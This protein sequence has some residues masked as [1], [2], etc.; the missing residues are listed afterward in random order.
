MPFSRPTLSDLVSRTLADVNSRLATDS[1]LRRADAQ[2]FSRVLAGVAHGLYGYLDWISN[3][4]IYDTAEQEVLDRWA[5]IWLTTPRKPAAVATGSVT[6]TVAAGAVIPAGTQVR[7]LDGM[8]YQTT[9]D[10]T[11]A[12]PSATAPVEALEAGAAGNRAAGEPF[13]LVSPVPGV[14][15]SALAGEMAGGADEESD[16]SLRGRLIARIQ[17]PPQGGAAHDYI[18]WALEVP[19]VTRAWVVTLWDADN[20]PTVVLR[21]VR[22]NDASLIPDAGEVATMQDYIDERRPVTAPFVAAAPIPDTLNFTI[23]VTPNTS[24]VKDAVTAEL[25]DLLLREAQPSG[26]LLLSHIR[27]A[28]S[29]AA[30]ETNYT[31][32]SPSADVVSASGHM[33]VFG[34]ITWT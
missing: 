9:A 8:A 20:L 34:T 16:D 5:S 12:A 11:I 24:T 29:A 21:F 7:A 32:S 4:V 2:V 1:T 27:A 22:D 14:Q 28:I 17:L 19:G 6:F 30:G 33:P 25:K 26:T 10:A 18:A 15:T 23:S 13:T 3:Q 31:M